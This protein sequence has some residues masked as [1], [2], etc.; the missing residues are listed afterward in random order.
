MLA[1]A[2][3]SKMDYASR[4]RVLPHQSAPCYNCTYYFLQCARL[5]VC[6]HGTQEAGEWRPAIHGGDRKI[7]LG[8]AFFGE[9]SSKRSLAIYENF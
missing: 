7:S 9:P 3:Q 8:R 2:K 6:K 5:S 1:Q 4:F